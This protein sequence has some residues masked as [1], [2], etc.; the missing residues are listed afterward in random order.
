MTR[1]LHKR[2]YRVGHTYRIQRDW[3]HWTDIYI[4]ITRRFREPLGDISPQDI[5]KEGYSTL[6]EFKEAWIEING[7]WNPDMEVWAYEFELASPP[8]RGP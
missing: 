5:R 1:R 3:F 8:N 7:E 6:E 2:P 4:R